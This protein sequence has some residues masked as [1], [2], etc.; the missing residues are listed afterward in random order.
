MIINISAIITLVVAALIS[1]TVFETLPAGAEDA[2]MFTAL[3]VTFIAGLIAELI[4][5]GP[6]LFYLIPLWMA[7]LIMLGVQIHERHGILGILAVLVGGAALQG[8]MFVVAAFHERRRER[9]DLDKRLRSVDLRHL[10]PTYD[11]AWDILHEAVLVPRV[12][13]W[14]RELLEHD[15]RVA[16]LVE[17]WLT[18]RHPGLP[19]GDRLRR[20]VATYAEGAAAPGKLAAPALRTES[21]WLQAMIRN[22]DTLTKD[23]RR[24]A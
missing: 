9:R 23:A 1:A 3:G 8:L 5:L 16:A 13:P 17:R 12:T 21:E 20:L 24:P 15:H 22:R 7:A 19:G 18:E 2:R 4:G 10:N 11:Q 6:R 14:T